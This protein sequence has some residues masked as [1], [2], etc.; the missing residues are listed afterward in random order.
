MLE[1]GVKTHAR[2]IALAVLSCLPVAR[3]ADVRLGV[4]FGRSYGQDAGVSEVGG[5]LSFQRLLG[6][7]SL[8]VRSVVEASV[9]FGGGVAPLVRVDGDLLYKPGSFY[10]GGGIGSGLLISSSLGG[11]LSPLLLLNAHGVVGNDFGAFSLEGLVRFGLV[12]GV[13]VRASFPLR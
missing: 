4:Q 5:H 2:F 10:L 6:A 11:L 3:A 7:G 13:G 12:G 8:Q 1:C 9:L